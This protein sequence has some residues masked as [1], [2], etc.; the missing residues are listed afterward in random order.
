M[1]AVGVSFTFA[2]V[3]HES[4]AEV[5][6]YD[7]VQQQEAGVVFVPEIYAFVGDADAGLYGIVF[8]YVVVARFRRFKIIIRCGRRV[9][10][11]WKLTEYLLRL[12]A[13]GVGDVAGKEDG[14]VAGIYPCW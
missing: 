1:N 6:A 5:S 2:D 14:A 4:G 11:L 9:G 12:L 13:D 7:R 10:R 3:G 8:L